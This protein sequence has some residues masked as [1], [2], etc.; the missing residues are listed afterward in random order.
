MIN[1]KRSDLKNFK[2]FFVHALESDKKKLLRTKEDLEI[3]LGTL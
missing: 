2:T 3:V 1:I